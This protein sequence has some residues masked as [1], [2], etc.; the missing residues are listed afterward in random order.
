MIV[1]AV[2]L[3]IVVLAVVQVAIWQLAVVTG[4]VI[5][6]SVGLLWTWIPIFGLDASTTKALSIREDNSRTAARGLL[7]GSATASLIGVMCA[8]LAAK[9]TDD[10][11]TEILLTIGSILTVIVSWLTIQTVFTLR[12]AHRYYLAPVGGI[13]FP[14]GEAPNYHDFAY[15]SFTVGM[16]FQVSDT[17]INSPTVRRIVLQQALLAYVFG[18]VIIAVSI[19]LIASIVA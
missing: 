12:Y 14:G 16:T 10:Q 8:L 15:V 2:I 19:N 5:G 17:E 9:R 18:A 1:G 13:T 11:T 3:V 4:W 7:V 6:A